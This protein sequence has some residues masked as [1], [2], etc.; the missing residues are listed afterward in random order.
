MPRRSC[1]ATT[2]GRATSPTA[3][4]FPDGSSCASAGT[5]KDGPGLAP[6][7]LPSFGPLSQRVAAAIQDATGAP[8]VYFM[9]FGENYPHFHFLVIA[10]PPTSPPSTAVPASSPS[11][12]HTATCSPRSIAVGRRDVRAR[13][14]SRLTLPPIHHHPN[15]KG[16]RCPPRSPTPPP[17]AAPS[18]AARNSGPEPE[19]RPGAPLVIA[20]HGGT[21]TSEYFD[22]P[23]YSLLDRAEAAG[24]PVIALDRPNYGGSSPLEQRRLDHPRQRRGAEHRDRRDLGAARRRGIRSSS[25]SRT[26][27]AAPSRPRSPH[28]SRRGRCWASR[29]RVT[30]CACRRSPPAP[31]RRSRPSR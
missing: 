14:H 18:P 11:A 5:P 29:P 27:S 12:P 9:S 6:P 17:T 26:R 7:R 3:T 10:R 21:Y 30:S 13:A 20:L 25:S 15:P 16:R 1:T 31:G 19:V 24:V 2:P 22:I 28:R 8:T 4:T 23:G